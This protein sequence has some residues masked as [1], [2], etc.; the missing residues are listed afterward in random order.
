VPIEG[1]FDFGVV[2]DLRKT[3]VPKRGAT[4]ALAYHLQGLKVKKMFA[5]GILSESK[6]VHT[7]GKVGK[8]A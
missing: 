3:F 1:T 4:L 6:F 7:F 5:L 2:F 8:A